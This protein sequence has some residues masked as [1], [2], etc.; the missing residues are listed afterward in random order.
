MYKNFKKPFS[1]PQVYAIIIVGTRKTVRRD[2][3]KQNPSQNASIQYMKGVGVPVGTFP[4]GIMSTKLIIQGGRPLYGEISVSGMKNAALPILFASIL[5]NDVCTLENIPGVSDIS[6]SL[7]LLRQMG[8]HITYLAPT[9]IRI[10]TTHIRQGT[11]PDELVRKMRGSSYLL[12]AELG[13]FGKTRIAWPGGC[14]FGGSRPLDL[15]LKGFRALGARTDTEGGFVYAEAENGLTGGSFYLDI[16]SV[17][18]TVNVILASVFA[19]GTTVI[20]N[21]AREPHIVDLANFLNACGANITGAGTPVIKVRGVTSLHGCT[22]TII[23]DMIEA[24]TYMVAAAA[25]G[26]CVRIRSVIPKHVESITT[27]LCEMGVVVEEEDDA[28]LVKSTGNLENVN[29]QTLYYPGFPTDMHP[30]FAVLLCI[31]NGIGN[32]HEGV[33]VNR[34]RYV[35]ELC[36]MGATIIVDSQ[37]ATV[38]G[39]ERLVGAVVEA[40]DLRAGAALVVAGLAAEGV[41]EI[42]NVEYIKRGYDSIVEKLRGI[43]AEIREISAE[44]SMPQIIPKAN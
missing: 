25:T 44:D 15:H 3:K 31:A 11:S 23:P 20:D 36:K 16:A 7:E 19:K 26:G 12:G 37:N 4:F 29:I 13:R 43:G 35:E 38:V 18:A 5:V 30:Q 32:I 1:F 10:D 17:G 8:A 42:R 39:V 27:K 14:D 24:G 28:V 6:T 40:T 21:A 34:F 9:T 2:C 33:W 41:T 22:Y